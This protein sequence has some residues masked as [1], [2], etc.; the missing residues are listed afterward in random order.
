MRGHADALQ[1]A[2]IL[3]IR[4]RNSSRATM[5]TRLVALSTY[6]VWQTG[7]KGP[8]A[9]EQLDAGKQA[10]LDTVAWQAP[11]NRGEARHLCGPG[12]GSQAV[13]PP[14]LVPPDFEHCE[15][16]ILSKWRMGRTELEGGPEAPSFLT[17]QILRR[18]PLTQGGCLPWLDLCCNP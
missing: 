14:V 8:H 5:I 11:P 12:H 13:R 2:H 3:M 18:G 4:T 16:H 6:V 17:L 15:R 1:P 9:R 7:S 10:R